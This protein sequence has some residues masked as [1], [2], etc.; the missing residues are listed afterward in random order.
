MGKVHSGYMKP[1]G[2]VLPMERGMKK[3]SRPEKSAPGRQ[4][5][6]WQWFRRLG[7]PVP[8]DMIGPLLKIEPAEVSAAIRTGQL[9]VHTF[10]AAT[11]RI[12]RVVRFEDVDQFRKRRNMQLRM[13]QSLFSSAFKKW[14]SQPGKAA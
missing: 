6:L 8:V 3:T 10:K 12:F 14:L 1:H 7:D 9:P 2:V 5:T 13:Q 11:G 4:I